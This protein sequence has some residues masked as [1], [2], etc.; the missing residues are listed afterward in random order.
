MSPERPVCPMEG[1]RMHPLH[2][3]DQTTQQN[4]LDS[5]NCDC[6]DAKVKNA[7]L[8]LGNHL[9]DG[10]YRRLAGHPP[11]HHTGQQSPQV[12]NTT[13]RWMESVVIPGSVGSFS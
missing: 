1:Y 8:L 3:V 13:V 7:K 4:K 11:H 6:S 5:L 12:E 10:L 2:S 9:C